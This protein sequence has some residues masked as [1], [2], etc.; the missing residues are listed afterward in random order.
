MCAGF[1]LTVLTMLS[2]APAPEPVDILRGD[3]NC[4]G[5]ACSPFDRDPYVLAVMWPETHPACEPENADMNCDGRVDFFD[6]DYFVFCSLGYPECEGD[7]P[8]PPEAASLRLFLS[9]YGLVDPDNPGESNAHSP[10][11]DA[12]HNIAV[13]TTGGSRRLWVWAQMDE[14]EEGMWTGISLDVHATGTAVIESAHVWQARWIGGFLRRWNEACMDAGY[15]DAG[16]AEWIDIGAMGWT[17]TGVFVEYGEGIVDHQFDP[18]TNATPIAWIDVSGEG[19]LYF[20]VGRRG[21]TRFLNAGPSRINLGWNDEDDALLGNDF[22]VA[23]SLPE[24]YLIANAPGDLNCDDAIDN[25]DVDPF[26]LALTDTAAYRDAQPNCDWM[27][28]DLNNDGLVN[29]FDIDPFVE[30]LIMH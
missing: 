8:V 12:G 30:L 25:F 15:P 21:I 14:D 1:T 18:V 28:A 4:D 7:P 17:G 11:T 22:G 10:V 24:A 2:A 29:N 23:S 16:G 20:S 3:I 26:V 19:E 6:N 9:T 27:L 13:A 5:L